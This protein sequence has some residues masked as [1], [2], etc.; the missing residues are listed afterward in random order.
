MK[1]SIIICLLFTG[2][3]TAFNTK[4]G[5]TVLKGGKEKAVIQTSAQCGECQEKIEG[6]VKKLD[7]VKSVDLNLDNKKLT[8][9]FD[10]TKVKLEEIKTAIS[11]VGYDADD[12]KANPT[13]Y[14]KLSSCCKKGG[15][16]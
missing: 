11:N 9:T 7:G 8:V 5:V 14:E 2:L 3:F 4:A 10:P 6:A 1:K 15:H 13:A 12:V 16:E